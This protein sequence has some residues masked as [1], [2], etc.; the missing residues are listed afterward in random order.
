MGWELAADLSEL[1]IVGSIDLPTIGYTYATMNQAINGTAAYDRAAFE[2]PGGGIA[3]TQAVWSA[4]RSD[5]QTILGRTANNMQQ[6]AAVITNAV[7][8]Y[9]EYDQAAGQS[10]YEA[11]SNGQQPGVVDTEA[12]Y[13]HQSPPPVVLP[14][15]Y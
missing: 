10:L 13:V 12:K 4:L 15:G 9:A 3:A 8:A 2:T 1:K 11:W 6:A 5:L 7:A 14:D